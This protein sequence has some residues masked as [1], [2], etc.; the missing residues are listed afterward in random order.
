[1]YEIDPATD[2]WNWSGYCLRSGYGRVMVKGVRWFAHRLM[3]TTERGPIPDGH[4]V[5]HRCDNP[6]CVNPEHLF[7]GTPADNSADMKRKGRQR[8]GENHPRSKLT[9]AHVAALRALKGKLS[10]RRAGA[11]FGISHVQVLNIWARKQRRT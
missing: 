7:V 3:W 1:M 8:R 4:Y 9:D 5:L 6:P 2:C 10:S 11:R